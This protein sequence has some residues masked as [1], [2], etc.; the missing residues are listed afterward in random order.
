MIELAY[1]PLL[2][3]LCTRASGAQVAA[4]NENLMATIDKL[5]RNGCTEKHPVAFLL[6]LMP[7]C[8]APDAHWRRRFAEQRKMTA[9]QVF[10]TVI[11][12]SALLR[13]V[14][15][16]MNWISP[17]PPHVKSMHHATREE[18]MAWIEL[19]Q[20]TPLSSLTSLF[21]RLAGMSRKTA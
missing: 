13:G 21:D 20:G 2:H 17:D 16:A 14:M 19:V 1:N 18:A 8:D 7:G 9:P 15:T 5:D 10:V 4:E 6:E 11:T 3:V 12:T